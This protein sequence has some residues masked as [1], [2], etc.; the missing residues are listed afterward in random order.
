MPKK[1]VN[2]NSPAGRNGFRIAEA[3]IKKEMVEGSKREYG[4]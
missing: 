4:F 2:L 1:L 3:E